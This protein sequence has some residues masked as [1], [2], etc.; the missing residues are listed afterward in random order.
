MFRTHYDFLSF[1]RTVCQ[2]KVYL[3]IGVETGQTLFAKPSVDLAVGVDPG[4]EIRVPV[5]FTCHFALF[6]TTSDDFFAHD[7]LASITD[8]KVDLTFVDGLHWSDFA[9]R[10]FRNAEKLSDQNGVIVIHD[11]YPTSLPEASRDM[12]VDGN[13]MGDV[14]KTVCA[15]SK[16]RPDLKIYNIKD[17]PPSGMSVICG[18]NPEDET[19]F[20]RYD[21]VI[22]YMESIDYERDFNASILPEFISSTS[23]RFAR[24]VRDLQRVDRAIEGAN[25]PQISSEHTL[26]PAEAV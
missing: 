7:L 18:L 1:V 26:T 6:K 3:E 25:D 13:W 24:L 14:F 22:S 12:V 2:P 15:L 8:R 5:D 19:L 16:F 9:L 21:E 20:A 11:I 4:F 23:P 17:I 10:D